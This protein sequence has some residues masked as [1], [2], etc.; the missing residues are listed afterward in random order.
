MVHYMVDY[1]R[2]IMDIIPWSVIDLDTKM[3]CLTWSID[4]NDWVVLGYQYNEGFNNW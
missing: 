4:E 3:N 1:T 2:K